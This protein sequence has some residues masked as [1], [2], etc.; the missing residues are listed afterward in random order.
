MFVV[1]SLLCASRDKIFATVA[2]TKPSKHPCRHPNKE[3]KQCDDEQQATLQEEVSCIVAYY[4][5]ASIEGFS[6]SKFCLKDALDEV[7]HVDD[8]KVSQT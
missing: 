3:E 2:R 7:V 1:D 6:L 4:T 5:E 8:I